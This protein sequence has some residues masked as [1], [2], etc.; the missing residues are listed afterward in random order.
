MRYYENTLR[1]RVDAKEKYRAHQLIDTLMQERLQIKFPYSWRSMP[2]PGAENY[3]AVQ[4]RSSVATGLPG[5]K[6]LNFTVENGD[7]MQFSCNMS[8]I[9][10]TYKYEGGKEKRLEHTGST[11]EVIA[12]LKKHAARFGF[13]VLSCVEESDA[14]FHIK[15]PNKPVFKLG[16]KELSVI[17]RVTDAG[18]AEKT[19]IEGIGNKRIFGFG[20]IW[21]LEVL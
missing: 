13:D 8:S 12:K 18:M 9:I 16:H 21:S 5:E 3:S 7:I 14:M 4:I 10:R 17:V 19:I 20:Y 2:F 6:E 1:L 11:D 15:K